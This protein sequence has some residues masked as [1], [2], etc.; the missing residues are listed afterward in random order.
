VKTY[1]DI[2]YNKAEKYVH[3]YNLYKTIKE[4]HDFLV[5]RGKLNPDINYSK[6]QIERIF[7]KYRNKRLSILERDIGYY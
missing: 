6:E 5:H 2:K 3:N 4:K 1:F 7:E